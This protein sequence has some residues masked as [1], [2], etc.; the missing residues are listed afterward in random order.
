MAEELYQLRRKISVETEQ[1]YN[2]IS[3]IGTKSHKTEEDYQQ[4]VAFVVSFKDSFSPMLKDSFTQCSMDVLRII[5]S[6]CDPPDQKNLSIVCRRFSRL[7]RTETYWKKRCILYW[8]KNT[9]VED[10]YLEWITSNTK[11]LTWKRLMKFLSEVRPSKYNHEWRKGYQ[12]ENLY[13]RRFKDGKYLPEESVT[14]EISGDKIGI[15]LGEILEG[16]NGRGEL[17]WKK[18]NSEEEFCRGIWKEG[19]LHGEGERLQ[20]GIKEKGNFI[21]GEL[22][23]EGER[24]ESDSYYTGRF[25]RGDMNGRG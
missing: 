2:H 9:M 8:Q 15:G 17:R 16:G 6:Q 25:D 23:G 18:P 1:L 19:K 4:I 12:M 24:I 21:R 13:L 7:V 11:I 20:N 5:I 14:I 3:Q 22:S 10:S